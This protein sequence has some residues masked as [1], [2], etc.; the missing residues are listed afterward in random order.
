MDKPVSDIEQLQQ[1]V[2]ALRKQ[3]EEFR[4]LASFPQAN[5][6]SILELTC[7][8]QLVYLNPAAQ[9]LLTQLGQPDCREFV[10]ENLAEVCKAHP[11]PDKSSNAL[12][13]LQELIINGKVFEEKIYY[14]SEYE[15][16]R[17]Y[18]NDI[19]DHRM[20]EDELKTK[21]LELMRTQDFLEAVTQG[22]DVL[23]ATVDKNYCYTYFNQAYQDEV[24]H[25]SGIKIAIGMKMLDAFAQQPELQKIVQD[26]WNQPLIGEHTN[27]VL[28]FGDPGRYKRI[29]NVLHTPI[30][31]GEGKVVGAGEV[32]YNIS[33]EVQAQDALRES[34]ARFRM[35]LKN[36]P[37]TVAAQDKDLKFIWAYNQRTQDPANVI[38]KTDQ[39]LFPPDVANW[40]T[41]LKHQVLS[42]GKELHTQGWLTSGGQR[43]YLDIFLEPIRD[44]KGEITGVGV[45]TVDLTH[46]KLAE[47]AL[48][49]SEER[50][51]SLFEGM[52]EGF[53]IHQIL[54]DE[55]NQPY[56]YR[57]LDINPAF[58]RLTGFKRELVVGKTYREVLP[59]EGDG[60][61]NTYAKVALTG[62]SIHFE[63]YS[64]T[65]N[66]HYEVYAYRCA[67]DQFAS[68]FIDITERKKMEEDL[69]INL[70]KYSVLFDTLPV[71]V[72][73]TDCDGQIIES[74]SEATRLLGLSKEEQHHRLI[75]G[76]EWEVVHTD[77]T[78]M[79]PEEFASVRAMNEQRRIEDVEMGLVR[80]QDQITWIKVNAAPLPLENYGVVITYNDISGRIQAEEALRQAHEKLELTVLKRTEEL[81]L[82][83]AELRR[84]I[85]ERMRVESELLR[86]TKAVAAERQRFN[87]VLEIMP[88]YTILLTPDYHVAFANRYF[89]E[90]FGEDN[91]KPCYEYLFGL[92]EPCENCETYKVMRSRE[93]HTWQWTGPDQRDYD[94]FDFPFKDVDGSDLILEV[95]IDITERKRAE[96]MLRSL[97][98][99]N[100]SLIEAN[101]DALVTI[102]PDGK[103]GDVN[104][105]TEAIT[106]VPRQQLVGTDFH[107][108]F[109]DP[110]KAR[111]GY[112]QVFKTG[113]VRDYELEIQHTDGHVTPVVY[114]ASVFKNESGGVSGVFAA[115]R[116]ISERK[117]TERQLILLTTALEA[118]ANGIILV[119]KEGTIIW[120]N[121]AFSQMTGFTSEEVVG[122]NP[123]LFKSG[124]QSGEFYRN[125]WDTI[126]AG[127]V[128]RG[129]LINRRK[130]GSLYSE[131]QIITPVFDQ[132]GNITNFISIRQDIT[133]HKQAEDALRKSEEQYRSL[134]QATSQIVWET[135]ARGA[136]VTDIPLWREF[137][138]Q[139]YAEC[140]GMGWLEPVHPADQEMVA[141]IWAHA[142]ETKSFYETECRIKDRFGEYGDFSVRGVPIMDREGQITSWVGTSTDITDKKNY[143]RQLIQAEKHA[144]IGRMVGSVTHEINNPLQTIKNCLYLLK[145]DTPLDSPVQEPLQ[146]AVSETQRLSNIVGQLRQLYRPQAAQTMEPQELKSIITEVHSLIL[147]HLENARVL[148]QPSLEDGP[149]M[150]NC[151]KDQLIEVFL[152]I[153]LNAIEA[154]QSTGGILSVKM[155]YTSD[156]TQV[157]VVFNDNGPGIKPEILLHLF[158]PF[159]TSK[160][161]GLGLGLSICYGIIQKHNG[162]ITVD[163]EPG[164]GTSFTIWLPLLEG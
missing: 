2:I 56:D 31:D 144:A 104:T 72:T 76:K 12:H 20:V 77:R 122:Q 107:A 123:R 151:I 139:S 106:G 131:E 59:Q 73:I 158:E 21:T 132:A 143:E 63:E 82:A 38:G 88:V 118:A 4:H 110:K 109:T 97:N 46:A 49:E 150:V 23:I 164:E 149:C 162:Q 93:R 13:F 79:R 130:D 43:L 156:K 127:K 75:G 45:A 54:V 5:P 26:E 1:E 27:K 29:Y 7:D 99:Y 94:V 48:R 98:A 67:P 18:I 10:P 89:R 84:E 103:I 51:R 40:T 78:P 134:V 68:I 100:R 142:V 39:D 117:Q 70:T 140:M 86:Q 137:T 64:P 114:N 33:T 155:A 41:D 36:A 148:W 35:V 102:T 96:D 3:N 129:E 154:M 16:F 66:K 60:W 160:E 15:T 105:V 120:S 44:E 126:L 135:D 74:N 62:E 61:I 65:L 90:R 113:T 146:M 71:G 37:V 136:V 52:T 159:T 121:P 92:A 161:F 153:S 55:H 22:T 11:D 115:A 30:R 81:V 14:S 47:E 57:F 119:D 128:W 108:Y 83:N 95:G 124:K 125:L 112:E 53:A 58:E 138:G 42:T 28:D 116:D 163:S 6:A 8:G 91:G 111:Q 157:G 133:E 147:T 145:L 85:N 152:N 141:K 50:Y 25:I 24:E 17:I 80:D 19:T 69:R 34:E 87:D 32:A 101:L 9:Q